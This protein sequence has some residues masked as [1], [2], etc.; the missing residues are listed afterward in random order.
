MARNPL[1]KKRQMDQNVK[2]GRPAKGTPNGPL[3][4]GKPR[5][6]DGVLLPAKPRTPGGPL[7][8]GKPRTR[9]GTMPPGK[10]P[11]RRSA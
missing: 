6:G 4:P 11:R 9:G 5:V 8:P 2:R 3:L 10:P 7:K 1:H